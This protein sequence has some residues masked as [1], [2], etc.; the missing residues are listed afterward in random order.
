MSRGAF[1][2]PY[3]L[4]VQ[5]NMHELYKLHEYNVIMLVVGRLSAHHEN[6][7]GAT[8]SIKAGTARLDNKG[9]ATHLTA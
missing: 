2:L 5:N 7:R 4:E 6:L 1:L 3:L 9:I 8:S